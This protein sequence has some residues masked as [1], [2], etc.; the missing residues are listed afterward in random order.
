MTRSFVPCRCNTAGR[1]TELLKNIHV[2]CGGDITTSTGLRKFP[3]T[4]PRKNE[5]VS[6]NHGHRAHE[7]LFFW[8]DPFFWGILITDLLTQTIMVDTQTIITFINFN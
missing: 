8:T 3:S 2:P 7:L 6:N 5:N 1:D 4:I